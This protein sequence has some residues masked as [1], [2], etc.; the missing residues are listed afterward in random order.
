MH[1]YPSSAK[2]G[3]IHADTVRYWT[4]HACTGGAHGYIPV[5]PACATPLTRPKAY[6]G[7]LKQHEQV[8]LQL[9]QIHPRPFQLQQ[10]HLL[11]DLL[12]DHCHLHHQDLEHL[13][14]LNV[15]LS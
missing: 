6:E 3:P 12:V 13:H 15:F 10:D 1:V 7:L 14:F 4:V 5:R 2:Y 9:I 8:L 11:E